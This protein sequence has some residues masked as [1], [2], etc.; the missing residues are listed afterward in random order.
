MAPAFRQGSLSGGGYDQGISIS[1]DGSTM[2]LCYDS[3][4]AWIWNNSTDQWDNV[5]SQDR[6]PAGF[7]NWGGVSASVAAGFNANAIVCAPSDGDR[8]YAIVQH[9]GGGSIEPTM[10]WRSIDRCATWEDTEYRLPSRITTPRGLGPKMAVDPANPDVVYL[11]DAAGVIHRTD[12]GGDTWE[13]PTELTDL[14]ISAVA[15]G[16][17]AAD[18]NVLTFASTPADVQTRNN[19]TVY[20]ANIS[21]LNGLTIGNSVSSANGTTVTMALDIATPSAPGTVEIGDTI[22]F[23]NAA[24]IAFDRSSGTTGGKTNV[25]YIGWAYGASAVYVS[26]DAGATWEATVDGPAKVRRIDCSSDGVLYACSYL[27]A[28]GFETTDA[29]QKNVWRYQEGTW[30]NFTAAAVTGAQGNVWNGVAADP[31]N[32]GNVV[33]V[34]DSGTFRMSTD[35]GTNW[36]TPNPT[37]P[38]RVAD[39]SP[40]L[41]TTLESFQTNGAIMFDP[42]VEDKVWVVMG[43]GCWYFTPPYAATSISIISQNKNHQ[44]LIVDE[45]VKPPGGDLIVAV[46]DRAALRLPNP[47]VEPENDS[48][49][50]AVN[51]GITH[52]WAV[53]YAKSDPTFIALI[54]NSNV[55]VST[56]GGD[57]WTK[58]TAQIP[59]VNSGGAIAAQTPL[60]I[61][62]FPANDA[63]PGY[64]TDGG[65][66]WSSCLFAGNTLS[67]GWSFSVFNNRHIMVADL[68]DPDTYYAYNYNSAVSTGGLWRST[69]SGAN[70]SRMHDGTGLLK[71]GS[72]NMNMIAIPGKEGH[73]ML[74]A[75]SA[76]NNGTALF[77]SVDAGTTW[78]E[79]TNTDICWC[80]AVGKAAPGADYPT[81]FFSGKLTGDA[82]LGVFMATDFTDDPEEMPTWTR[83]S[84]APA[85]SMDVSKSLC[86][87]PDRHGS[88]YVGFGSTGYAFI[89]PNFFRLTLT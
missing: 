22:V 81:I 85:D 63:P 19:F 55:W 7:D 27:Q 23:G 32:A 66:N 44:G 29:G 10:V 54:A 4:N 89:R 84:E 14:L 86:G 17:T 30:T 76:F 75:G 16:A 18:G 38:V 47:L 26:D 41:A 43:I 37:G 77:R 9:A 73:L 25:I 34:R 6:M 51:G 60:N 8:V 56:D 39:D 45:I 70:W 31:L 57:T 21:R 1:D 58:K 28:A 2:L 69:D 88:V 67:T 72:Q 3:A 46:Q 74:S 13:R 35:Y 33:A 59:S 11:T 12:D 65:A 49:I 64:T 71:T 42:V 83:L 80:V 15:T 68:V 79:V 87:D 50:M 53:D 61:V 40:W 20:A 36:T 82:D 78:D 62:W 48:G 5:F 52:G 24:G